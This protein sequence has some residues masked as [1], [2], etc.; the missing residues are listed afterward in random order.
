MC[1]GFEIYNTIWVDNIQECIS[2]LCMECGK[3]ELREDGADVVED[4]SIT[5]SLSRYWHG[6]ASLLL[7]RGTVIVEPN[8][9]PYVPCP[10]VGLNHPTLRSH[11]LIIEHICT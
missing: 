7:C 2:S 5:T 8:L 10:I 9:S 3:A 4:G 1:H 11:I 6:S